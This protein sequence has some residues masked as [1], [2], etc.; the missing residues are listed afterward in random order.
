METT[1][2]RNFARSFLPWIIAAVMLLVYLVT[3]DKVV[4]PSSVHPLARATGIDWRPAF[5]APLNWL[6]TLPIRW[7]P[8]G[9]QLLGLNF[10]GALCAALSLALLA[11]CVAL[12]PHD[13]TQLQ[14]DKLLPEESFL[15]IRF[16]WVPVVFAVLVCGLQRTFWEHAIVN[17]GE[18]LDLL[19]F[20]YCVRCLLE[21]RIEESNRWLYK[22]AVVYGVGITNNY[23]MIAFFPVLLV[24]LVWIKGLR[25]FRFDFLSR[26]FLLGLAGLSLYLLL[27][28][29]QN[30]SHASPI[31]FWQALKF[32]FGFQ[33]MYVLHY[34]DR[35]R[36]GWIAI[37]ALLP[38]LLAGIRWPG[39][40]GDTSPVG[41]AFTNVFAQI[42]HAG[43]LAFC[44]YIAF[45]PPAGPRELDPRLAFL[46]CYFLG[47]LS[48]GYYSGFL[49]LV[50]SEGTGRT[51]RQAAVP[52]ILNYAVT[53]FVCA[54]AL[55]VAGK[56]VVQNYPRIRESTART[57]HDY[58]STLLKSLP[59]KPAVVLSDDPI[60]L[61]AVASMADRSASGKYLFVESSTL[62]NPKYLFYLRARHGNQ[63]PKTVV[64][65][66]QVVP[67][68]EILQ[69]LSSVAATHELAYLHPSWGD[70]FEAFYLEPNNVTYILRPYPTN[71]TD[72]PVPSSALISQQANLWSTL[73]NGPLK[74]LKAHVAVL[75]EEA[76][77]AGGGSIHVANFYSLALDWWGVELQR[78]G[79]FDAAF[80]FFEEALAL[81]P[82]NASALINRDA[83]ILWRNGKQRLRELS[84]PQQEKLNLYRGMD[85][86]LAA[87][88]PIDVPEFAVEFAQGLVQAGLFR[89]AKQLV[90]RALAFA[91]DDIGFQMLLVNTYLA[92]EEPDRA[93]EVISKL[94]PQ[95]RTADPGPQIELARLEASAYY[96]KTN[97]T[98]AK[99]I[100]EEMVNRFPTY[101][102][103]YNALSQLY[104]TQSQRLGAENNMAAASAE[105]TNA[106]NVIAGQLTK[107]PRNASAHFNYGTLSMFVKDLDR[108][109]AEYTTVLELQK[110]NSAALLN[111]AMANLQNKKLDAAKRDYQEL[112]RRF[113]I[114]DYHVYYGLG[115]IAY[116]EKDW[117]AAR[118]N[119][120]QYLRYMPPNADE[121]KR[122]RE[123]L[124]E[125]KRKS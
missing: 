92:A 5:T 124:A 100:L 123:R 74:V 86:L 58:A 62:A 114:A 31:T 120:E 89:Q 79:E 59:E 33:K 39:S 72:A 10:I 11:R 69:T 20:A 90:H 8:S 47:A 66:D 118:E 105:L 24:A 17:T 73:E 54:G 35:W 29:V 18:A 70:F 94:R 109:I 22:L 46:P 48:I 13:R 55:F 102:A 125:V 111:R 121:A 91:P 2:T 6:V 76:R 116:M 34:H 53:F 14:R 38:L 51:R 23:A 43:L 67:R 81:N 12:W 113:S 88:G 87:C 50:F 49:L 80:K 110:D 99:K 96:A 95:M 27:P 75:S 42:L 60:R 9:A 40:F 16:T 36:A 7:L 115:E 1:P 19:L 122:I 30:S 45:D 63:W 84:K 64:G 4:T 97:F 21:Y 44:L 26:M 57:L 108:A 28:L 56:L 106:L 61:Y 37:Y 3:L 71:A 85:G 93:L 119:Y 25:F 83:N 52:P 77:R 112:L 82:D 98:Q 101:D 117:K 68:R 107:Q 32:N 15:N 65:N 78:A 104:V 41:S 103:T